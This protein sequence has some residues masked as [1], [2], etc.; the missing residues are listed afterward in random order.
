MQKRI[1]SLLVLLMTAV[2][3]AWAETITWDDT[4]VF[5]R[6]NQGVFITQDNMQG[7]AVTSTSASATYEGIT[8]SCDKSDGSHLML[9]ASYGAPAGRLT[10]RGASGDSFT[11]T[12]PTGKIFTKIE[13]DGYVGE[14]TPYGDWTKPSDM[15]IAWSG[16]AANTVTLGSVNTSMPQVGRIV[17]YVEEPLP[18]YTVTLKSG[19]EDATK[20]QGKAGTGDYQALPLTGVEAGTAV[21][22]KYFGTKKVESVKAVKA[23][24]VNPYA[25]AK[26]GDLF[27]SDGTFSTTLEA[28]KTPIGVIA[29]L[30][31]DAFSENGTTVGGSAFVGHGLVM[32]LKNAASA[33][34]WSTENVSKFSGQEVTSVD[35]L[36]RTENVSGYTNTA[37]LTVDEATAAK[38]PAAAAAKNYTELTAPTGTTGWFL[39]S[40]QQWVKMMEGLGGLSD[41]APNYGESFFDN[42]H[43]AAD[44]WEAALSEAGSGN[45]DSMTSKFLWY[46]SSSECSADNAVYLSVDATATGDSYGFWW[47][48]DDK[49]NAGSRSRVRPVLAF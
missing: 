12:A 13:I 21:S 25:T 4:N 23:L 19:T 7:S 41:G 47:D 20:W 22:F 11:F 14:F 27:Y 43:T 18:G 32:C 31:T 33:I 8:I 34:A 1:L 28:G 29:Y 36:K 5:K 42:N 26:L 48:N 40:A 24:I 38:Y 2:T 44:K 17:F 3:G 46:W 37:T 35:G 45:Y 49:G 15:Q 10:L 39:P 9:C 30:G 16:T 6:E